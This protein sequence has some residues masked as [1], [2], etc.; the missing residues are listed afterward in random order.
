MNEVVRCPKCSA[1]MALGTRFCTRCGSL[2]VS[3]NL[4]FDGAS[5]KSAV[6]EQS[7]TRFRTAERV[8]AD[9]V[10]SFPTSPRVGPQRFPTPPSSKMSAAQSMQTRANFQPTFTAS[11]EAVDKTPMAP[12]SLSVDFEDE[13]IAPSSTEP[14][15]R[16]RASA[17]PCAVPFMDPT[18]ATPTL[19]DA[20]ADSEAI[21]SSPA[22]LSEAF[23][24]ASVLPEFSG[25]D[26]D[27]GFASIQD[28]DARKSQAVDSLAGSY[29]DLQSLFADMVAAH[30]A[31]IRELLRELNAGHTRCEW[32]DM[33][34]PVARA[35]KNA[36]EQLPDQQLHR[37]LCALSDAL[38]AANP[39]GTTHIS[40]PDL[41][42]LR[43]AYATLLQLLP[44][45]S[46]LDEQRARREPI[47]VHAIF[48]C[49]AGL[50][51]IQRDKLVAAGFTGLSMLC[52]ARAD[53]LSAA[54]GVPIDLAK[55]LV[56]EVDCFKR[57]AA[58]SALD[59]SR[60]SERRALAE[61]TLTLRHQNEDF[62]TSRRGWS[63]QE[64]EKK[65]R[66][67]REREETLAQVHIVLAQ[68]GELALIAQLE[69]LPFD[70]KLSELERFLAPAH[71]DSQPLSQASGGE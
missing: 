10:G 12:L 54:S 6:T 11:S 25:D 3:P 14:G 55:R 48:E 7:S 59:S 2:M 5:R 41:E 27:D 4:A 19:R 66:V 32:L 50:G 61:L 24:R 63:R 30:V 40:A 43:D 60:A 33:C 38:E 45:L 49:T 15:S 35:L 64:Q 16:P 1:D 53:E 17:R 9:P 23:E 29:A 46:D 13:L 52:M 34:R 28:G 51:Q 18:L 37:A 56:A 31:P 8:S 70:R 36:A 44:S 39:N 69:K 57:A 47:I 58:L 21:A 26:I 71:D 22:T 67:Q 42:K 65:R 68:L 62:E 20:F